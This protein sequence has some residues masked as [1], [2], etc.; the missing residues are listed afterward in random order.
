MLPQNYETTGLIIN[1][2]KKQHPLEIRRKG[3]YLPILSQCACAE[4]CKVYRDF[5]KMYFINI[6]KTIPFRHK[7]QP[8][9]YICNS[10]IEIKCVVFFSYLFRQ[11][12]VKKTFCAKPISVFIKKKNEPCNSLINTQHIF[13]TSCTYCFIFDCTNCVILLIWLILHIFFSQPE[14]NVSV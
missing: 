7:L 13:A 5:A 2:Y 14:K 3:A 11:Q 10:L 12:T 6:S 1:N 9:A 8:G 4:L